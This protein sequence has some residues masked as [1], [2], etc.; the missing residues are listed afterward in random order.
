[1]VA[2]YTPYSSARTF[3]DTLPTWMSVE[4]GERISAYMLYEMMYKNLPNTYTLQMRG[5]EDKPIYIPTGKTIIEATN[6]FLA[7]NWDFVV[8]PEVGNP[9]D[10]EAVRTALTS[11]FKREE[12][13]S[14]FATNR[15]WGLIRGDALWHIVADDTKPEGARISVYDIDPATYFPIEDPNDP[16]KIIGCH[17]V[18]QIVNDN[19]ETILRRH[20]YRRDEN[21]I[22]TQLA[23]F[24]VDAW[25]DRWGSGQEIKPV[26]PPADVRANQAELLTGFY[27]PAEITALPVYHVKNLRETGNPFGVS[28]MQGMERLYT[29]VNQTISDSELALALEG[30]G[31]YVTTSSPPVDEQG[32]ELPWRIKPGGVIEIDGEASWDRVSGVSTLPGLQLADWLTSSARE[33]SGVPD[34]A[35]GNV[36]VALAESGIAL[37]MKMAPLLA[38]NEEKEITILSV[39]DHML[40]DLVHM[41]MPVYEGTPTEVEVYSI[42]GNPLPVNRKERIDEI[43]ALLTAKVVDGEWARTELAKYGFEFDSGMTQ[44]IADE[45]AMM[46]E[47]GAAGDPFA[48]NVNDMLSG[49]AE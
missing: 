5:T 4:D 23:F 9:N 47:A 44:R 45:A 38:K 16:E 43:I 34:M 2:T 41:W 17:L 37:A 22:F 10:Q 33:A 18:T 31:V 25:D 21:G 30:I 39:M 46:S 29:G 36:D 8:D 28:E 13:Y 1:M 20:T 6:R 11:L 3:F 42:V 40:Y 19:D 48:K 7:R 12:M 32:N 24:E 14:K 26:A 27:L 15:R 49:G 35:V